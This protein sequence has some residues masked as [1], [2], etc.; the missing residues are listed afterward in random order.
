MKLGSLVCLREGTTRSA[1]KSLD[2]K[3]LT[4]SEPEIFG[5]I[6]RVHVLWSADVENGTYLEEWV[7]LDDIELLGESGEK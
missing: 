7:D 1:V 4:L 3:G 5:F 6:Q 2:V